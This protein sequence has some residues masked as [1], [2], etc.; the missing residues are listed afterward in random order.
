MTEARDVVV[1]KVLACYHDTKNLMHATVQGPKETGTFQLS[2]D[3]Q[4]KDF[5]DQVLAL[6]DD[7]VP[8]VLSIYLEHGEL[9]YLLRQGVSKGI[10]LREYLREMKVG[11]KA[12]KSPAPSNSAGGRKRPGEEAEGGSSKTRGN[13]STATGAGDVEGGSSKTR[14]R[15][16]ASQAPASNSS[17][18]KSAG[19]WPG[20]SAC[21]PAARGRE[22]GPRL[23]ELDRAPRH[24]RRTSKGELLAVNKNG[25]ESL[26]GA[27]RFWGLCGS[28]LRE[29]QLFLDQ[30]LVPNSRLRSPMVM[31]V[32][33]QLKAVGRYLSNCQAFLD[34]CQYENVRARQV[35]QLLLG[36]ASLSLES[37]AAF[38]ETLREQE[39]G[40]RTTWH[41]SLPPRLARRAWLRRRPR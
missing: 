20:P 26:S 40:R 17:R 2:L 7:K 33:D 4:L 23:G 34:N 16:H 29:V 6:W 21:R 31:A 24:K 14:A 8:K 13:H 30:Q 15:G 1:L 39:A 18:A 38:V 19:L 27:S 36:K 35:E 5:H 9:H 37:K 12:Q 10:T 32:L 22:L 3:K 25:A 28:F 41:D 11:T